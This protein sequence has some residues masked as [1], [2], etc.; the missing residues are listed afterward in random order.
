[1]TPPATALGLQIL[2]QDRSIHQYFYRIDLKRIK[3]KVNRII[4]SENVK[5]QKKN[6]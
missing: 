4:W 3:D 1:M 5:D 6:H 2:A